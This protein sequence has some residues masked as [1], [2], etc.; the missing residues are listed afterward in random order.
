M[1][2]RS[3]SF[4]N[5][6]QKL[7]QTTRH[8]FSA[9]P[10]GL[11]ANSSK[12]VTP[13]SGRKYP[14]EHNTSP[15]EFLPEFETSNNEFVARPNSQPNPTM[16]TT[17]TSSTANFLFAE[18]YRDNP[19]ESITINTEGYLPPVRQIMK[20]SKEKRKELALQ[21]FYSK[22]K[23]TNSQSAV[24]LLSSTQFRSNQHDIGDVA[25][26]VKM[27]RDELNNTKRGLAQLD[28]LVDE[29]ISWVHTH[30][31]H[32]VNNKSKERC[33]VIALERLYDI[34][35]NY[36]KNALKKSLLKWKK[37]SEFQQ[38]WDI[39]KRYCKLKSIEKLTNVMTIIFHKQLQIS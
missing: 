33:R 39:T 28:Y 13:K 9:S 3:I 5:F 2:R 1:E 7:Q 27:L 18:T 26:T 25:N 8:S 4:T 11:T 23:K 36:V 17:S 34:L 32:S 16:I 35:G 21:K 10:K 14:H 31:G 20:L 29:N 37:V 24:D 19:S 22:D 30:V 38:M 15:H 12:R 6:L